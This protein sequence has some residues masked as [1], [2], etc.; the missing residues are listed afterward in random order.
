MKMR[1]LILAAAGFVISL[2]SLPLRANAIVNGSFETPLT[3]PGGFTNFPSGSTGITGWTVVGP[4]ASIVSK[5]Y[6]AGCCHFPAEDGNQWL[7]LTGFLSNVSEGVQ[8]TVATTPSTQY[9]LSYW[10]G[11]VKDPFGGFGITSSVKVMVDGVL[12]DTVTN[13]AN[14]TTLGWQNFTD[15]F[16]ASGTTTTIAFLN[17]DPL[18]DNSNGLD[19]VSLDATGTTAVPEPGTLQ[20]FGVSLAGLGFLL[21]RRK[22][23]Q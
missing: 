17:N 18:S 19:N 15:V 1:L 2:T 12:I 13:S 14:T 22:S 5:T 3:I 21:Y 11:N 20:L 4:E 16:T 9:T 7:D 6:A 8:Q 23:V 10:V